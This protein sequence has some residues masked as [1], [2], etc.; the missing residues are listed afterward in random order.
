MPSEFSDLYHLSVAIGR[1]LR[2]HVRE[3]KLAQQ[4]EER[5]VRK[6]R[7]TSLEYCCFGSVLFIGTETQLSAGAQEIVATSGGCTPTRARDARGT[8]FPERECS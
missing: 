4:A 8:E 3:D 7:V 5:V 1:F 2:A 6:E